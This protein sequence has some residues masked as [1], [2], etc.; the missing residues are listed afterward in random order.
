MVEAL[1][2]I[3]DLAGVAGIGAAGV[4]KKICQAVQLIIGNGGADD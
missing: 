1:A 3:M 2:M 4:D